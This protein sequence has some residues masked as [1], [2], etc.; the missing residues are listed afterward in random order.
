MKALA[1]TAAAGL[2]AWGA[3][4]VGPALAGWAGL[5]AYELLVRAGLVFLALGLLESAHGVLR[6]RTGHGTG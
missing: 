2:A 1:G 6:A 3:W 5:G 4:S